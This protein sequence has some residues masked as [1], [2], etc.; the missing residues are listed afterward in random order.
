MTLGDY[1]KYF[2]LSYG[3]FVKL[4]KIH[5]ANINKN[6]SYEKL[7]EVD[8]VELG[9]GQ[10]FFFKDG[11][12]KLIYISDDA[13]AKKTWAE[14]KNTTNTSGTTVR[15]RAGKTS[16]QIIFPEQGITVSTVRD[17]VDFIEIYPPQP[18]HDYLANIYR[19]PGPFIR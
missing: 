18:L 5:D 4:H 12:L 19:E 11:Q 3:Q 1:R 8:R 15:S 13:L 6:V 10:W 14:F 16:N 2:T 7:T 9:T 17:A